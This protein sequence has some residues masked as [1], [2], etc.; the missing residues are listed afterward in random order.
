ME[1]LHKFVDRNPI[2]EGENEATGKQDWKKKGR[3]GER[4]KIFL[5]YNERSKQKQ[6]IYCE[7]EEHT[8]VKCT[9]ILRIGKLKL[10]VLFFNSKSKR[11]TKCCP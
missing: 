6:C 8:G 4:E 11:S 1:H 2:R 5:G 10:Y 9:K 3:W 7:S